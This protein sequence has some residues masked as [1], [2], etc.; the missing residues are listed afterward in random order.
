VKVALSVTMVPGRV[1]VI[2]LLAALNIKYWR[3]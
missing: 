1:E 2:T 3:S